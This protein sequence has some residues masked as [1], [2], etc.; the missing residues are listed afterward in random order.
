MACLKA[1]FHIIAPI[2]RNSVPVIPAIHSFHMIA[3]IARESNS[4]GKALDRLFVLPHKRYTK[5]R[6]LIEEQG[7]WLVIFL[8]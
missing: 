8:F 4:L 7:F 1:G 3:S 2:A 5:W 6:L